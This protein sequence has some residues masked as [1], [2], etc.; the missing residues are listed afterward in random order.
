MKLG[1][2]FYASSLLRSF[3]LNKGPT[4]LAGYADKNRSVILF[5]NWTDHTLWLL[6]VV[7]ATKGRRAQTSNHSRQ[8]HFRALYGMN[9]S[10]PSEYSCFL[11]FPSPTKAGCESSSLTQKLLSQRLNLGH[12][13]QVSTRIFFLSQHNIDLSCFIFSACDRQNSS[14]PNSKMCACLFPHQPMHVVLTLRCQ[15][16]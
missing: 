3:C 12:L 1:N 5:L 7:K 6:D 16:D 15:K 4:A 13:W 10:S 8:F 9:A 14:W 11:P 2:G